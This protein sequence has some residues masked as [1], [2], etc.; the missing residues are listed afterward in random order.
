[1]TTPW[2]RSKTFWTGITAIIAAVSGAVVGTLSWPEAI[3]AIFAAVQTLNLR[4]AIRRV[5][6]K[7][8]AVPGGTPP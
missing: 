5:E 4:S 3:A 1:M 2:Y 7:V 6:T 8:D